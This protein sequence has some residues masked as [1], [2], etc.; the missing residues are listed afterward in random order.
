MRKGKTLGP[1]SKAQAAG[2]FLMGKTKKFTSERLFSILDFIY[3]IEAE[4]STCH[5]NHSRSCD[6]MACV[7]SLCEEGLLKRTTMKKG[8]A[9][10]SSMGV[11]SEDLTSVGYKCNF[12]RNYIEEVAKK[13][14]F[15][16][17]DYLFEKLASKEA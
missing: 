16:L 10:G 12:D 3:A 2:E 9:D 7:N 11:T 14:D 8:G 4:N 6:Y 1:D 15:K 13:I 5:T 17:D